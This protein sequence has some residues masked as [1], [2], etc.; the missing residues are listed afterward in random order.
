[1]R[2]WRAVLVAV[3]AWSFL[4]APAALAFQCPSLIKRAQDELGALPTPRAPQAVNREPQLKLVR[5]R[6]AAAQAAH[7]RGSHGDSVKLANEA[8][9]MLD[10]IRREGR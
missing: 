3:I 4:G 8:L 7:D 6:L 2:V 9:E 1:M 10:F 5:D